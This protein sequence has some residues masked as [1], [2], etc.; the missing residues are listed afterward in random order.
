VDTDHRVLTV[1]AYRDHCLY[2]PPWC[3]WLP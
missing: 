1:A 3:Q 2:S